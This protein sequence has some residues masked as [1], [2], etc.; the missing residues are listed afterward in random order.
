MIVT[1]YIPNDSA[2]VSVGA[3]DVATALAHEAAKRGTDIRIVRNGSRGLFWLEPLVE[4][5]HRLGMKFGLWVEPE[6]V[7]PD[8]DLYRAYPDQVVCVELNRGLVA[9]PFVPFGVSPISEA[10]VA[11]MVSPLGRVLAA[12]LA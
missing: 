10:K 3:D 12:A 5:V 1:L 11:K 9:D 4:E 2:A 8:S 7:N 6:M